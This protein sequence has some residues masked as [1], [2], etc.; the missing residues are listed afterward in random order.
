[1]HKPFWI[2]ALLAAALVLPAC[3]GGDNRTEVSTQTLGQE[4]SDLKKAYEEGAMTESEYE[5]A[6]EAVLRR[7]D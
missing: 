5:D 7:Y 2:V 3:G 6:K 1:M 4:L